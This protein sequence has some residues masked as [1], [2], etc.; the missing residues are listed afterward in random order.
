M[1][2]SFSG[3]ASG[4]DTS[5]WVKSLTALKQAKVTVLED[6]KEN[7]IDAKDALQSIRSFF[8]SFRSTIERIT[9]SRFNIVSMDLFAQNI[10]TSANL[11]VLTATATHEAEEGIYNI[12][13]D[14][15]ATN[16]SAIS[17]FKTTVQE[18]TRATANSLL[19][20]LGVSAGE[21]LVNSPSDGLQKGMRIDADDTIQSFIDK[22]KD[23]GVE[24]SFNEKTSVFSVN[25]GAGD[26]MDIGN[27]GII[28][29]LHL[30]GVNE[31]YTS[32]HL[33]TKTVTETFN[34]AI[35]STYLHEIGVTNGTVI[36]E[37]NDATFTY[38]VTNTST[39]QNFIDWLN[40]NHIDAALD[41]NGIFSIEDAEILDTSTSNLK[42][43]FGLSEEISS[44]SQESK[45][46]SYG[47]TIVTTTTADLTTKLSELGD[48]I[49]ITGNQTVHVYDSNNVLHTITVTSSSTLNSFFTD[50][51]EAGLNAKLNNDGTVEITGGTIATT[52]SFDAISALGL[53]FEPYTGWATGN[54][55]TETIETFE[56]VTYGTRLV[57]DLGV[58][59]G[60][61]QVTKPDGTIDYLKIYS[62]Q[63]IGMM[64]S[65]LS[66]MGI[67]SE[68]NEETG[69]LS[70][71]GG[72]FLTL[73]DSDVAYLFNNGSIRD[74]D[75]SV[76][77]S[78]Y[79]KATDLLTLLYGSPTISATQ[80]SVSQTY[81]RSRALTYEVTNTYQA[82]K[83][84]SLGTLGL[85]SAGNVIF[86]VRGEERTINVATTT[87]IDELLNKFDAVG[88]SATFDEETSK[89]YLENTTIKTT[90]TGTLAEVLNLEKTISG[91]YTTS[92]N[93]ITTKIN[94]I[95]ATRDTLLSE[96]GITSNENVIVHN[97]V[98]AAKTI[99]VT[100]NT[101]LG[102]LID[103]I[104]TV[105]GVTATLEDGILNIEGGYLEN[106]VVEEALGLDTDITGFSNAL[107]I[108]KTITL[109]GTVDQTSSLENIFATMGTLNKVASGYNLTFNGK[110]VTVSAATT[111]DQVINQINNLGGLA[112]LDT[113]GR[114]VIEGGDLAGTVANALGITSFTTTVSVS[115]TGNIMNTTTVVA[116]TGAT[117][118]AELGIAN[119][120]TITVKDALNNQVTV[121]T[122]GSAETLNNLF[123]KLGNANIEASIADGVVTIKSEKGN[124]VEGTIATKLGLNK[125]TNT[126]VVNTTQNS[127]ALTKTVT[128]NATND[129]TL[130]QIFDLNGTT[131][132]SY[133]LAFN[134]VAISVNANTNL[135]NIMNTIAERGGSA[136]IDAD[137]IL[138]VEG[139]TLTGTVANALGITSV[140]TTIGVTQSGVLLYQEET[141]F[142]DSNTTFADLG[143]TGNLITTVYNSNDATVTTLTVTTGDT[144]GSFINQLKTYGIDAVIADG[145]ISLSSD[146]GRYIKDTDGI[147][148]KLGISTA[149]DTQ[150]VSTAQTSTAK[151]THS[152]TELAD[153][154]TTLEAIFAQAGKTVVY[155]DTYFNGASVT[156]A[157]TDSV[158]TL[159][160]KI[161]A[162][163]G[164][165]YLDETGRLHVDNG[166]FTGSVATNLGMVAVITTTAVSATGA[167]QTYTTQEFITGDTKISALGYGASTITVRGVDKVLLGTITTNADMTF[168]DILTA[169]AGYDISGTITNGVITLTSTEGNYVEGGIV[170]S[171]GISSST[172]ST[173]GTTAGM[174][175]TSSTAITYTTTYMTTTLSESTKTVYGTAVISVTKP[176]THLVDF[177][178]T[179][180]Y[181]YD[182]VTVES[183]T[184][185]VYTTITVMN[186][187]TGT[188]TLYITHVHTCTE[189]TT[190]MV[191][192]VVTH[193]LTTTT[194]TPILQT[195]TVKATDTITLET[196]SIG[197]PVTVGETAVGSTQV[198]YYKNVSNYITE[199]TKITLLTDGTTPIIYKMA[200][201]NAGTKVAL[202]TLSSSA[203]VG[204][205]ISWINTNTGFSVTLS[206]GKFV[207]VE[208]TE[209]TNI[210][211]LMK[212]NTATAVQIGN[213]ETPYVQ[214]SISSSAIVTKTS[215]TT[216]YAAG[217]S[218]LANAFAA[219]S[220]SDKIIVVQ[221]GLGAKYTISAAYTIANLV[222]GLNGVGITTEY[223]GTT[224]RFNFTTSPTRITFYMNNTSNILAAGTDPGAAEESYLQTDSTTNQTTVTLTSTS[225]L[226]TF[227]TFSAQKIYYSLPNGTTGAITVNAGETA[228][229]LV[230]KLNN[231][232]F[233]ASVSNGRIRIGDG[234]DN[235]NPVITSI[236]STLANILKLPTTGYPMT[237][238]YPSGITDYT[239]G[240]Y[241][242]NA[243]TTQ[244][245]TLN[246]TTTWKDLFD[247]SMEGEYF[248]LYSIKEDGTMGNLMSSVQI[249]E[250]D[251]VLNSFNNIDGVTATISNG[252]LTYTTE[253]FYL[254]LIGGGG[255]TT[256][257]SSSGGNL[258]DRFNF[259][260]T[261]NTESGDIETYTTVVTVETEG[262]AVVT[263]YVPTT[264][265]TTV[266]NTYNLNNT[267]NDFGIAGDV[268]TV[269]NLIQVETYFE[270]HTRLFAVGFDSATVLPTYTSASCVTMDEFYA[271]GNGT[272]VAISSASD[273]QKLSEMCRTSAGA[274]ATSGVTFF[275]TNDIDMEGKAFYGIGLGSNAFKGTFDGCGYIIEDVTW[276]PFQSS[277]NG[278]A[279]FFNNIIGATIKNL[280]IANFSMNT[281][282]AAAVGGLVGSS[283][284]GTIENCHVAGRIG[285]S[286][287]NAVMGG[288]IGQVSAGTTS[289][290]LSW[291]NIEF[292]GSA[293]AIGGAVGYATAALVMD[294]VEAYT[295][296]TNLFA[297][298]LYYGGLIGIMQARVSISHAIASV[299]THI[300]NRL[301]AGTTGSGAIVGYTPLNSTSYFDFSDVYASDRLLAEYS[302]VGGKN[303]SLDVRVI[304][305]GP[306]HYRDV[307]KADGNLTIEEFLTELGAT[308][309]RIVDG[310]LYFE[311]SKLFQE[312][313]FNHGSNVTNGASYEFGKLGTLAIYA[314]GSDELIWKFSNPLTET[315]NVSGTYTTTHQ[316]E[317]TTTATVY[318]TTISEHT[319]EKTTTAPVTLTI[320][321]TY[322]Y[323]DVSV[324]SKTGYVSYTTKIEE[325][326]LTTD[327]ITVKT[328]GSISTTDYEIKEVTATDLVINTSTTFNQLEDDRSL[329]ANAKATIYSDGVFYTVTVNANDTIG[330][331]LTEL[332]GYG[333]AGN[334]DASGKVNL[335][336]DKEAYIYS[337]DATLKK[338]LAITTG[339]NNTYKSSSYVIMKNSTS[340]AKKETI[341]H[342]AIGSTT[343]EQ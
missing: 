308:N 224:G 50:L 64:M 36:V 205:F 65:D 71:T 82:T 286:N 107:G 16:T 264:G 43:A 240:V 94:D 42:S 314:E 271:T 318:K 222:S 338:A 14:K 17:K 312:E 156:I 282:N 292:G 110:T 299:D 285:S 153:G 248:Y 62:G 325:T 138:H 67:Y 259:T 307:V 265:G 80:T 152:I 275:L 234:S 49:T 95:N 155:D 258:T 3:L 328:T 133:S 334:I 51:K 66:N 28:D 139:G 249:S 233:S 341:T 329:T 298:C 126:T 25:V 343:L 63:T 128:Y 296:T 79:K 123:D 52:G 194:S 55:L 226:S 274:A 330:D 239:T 230:T 89:I 209:E 149:I 216:T 342:T 242:T 34:A 61:L 137:G 315:I 41:E 23:I 59:E 4:L 246:A 189:A 53:N 127:A 21:I 221:E 247:K 125:V 243:A 218:Y 166:T 273:I 321:S 147:A 257:T 284:Q 119:N 295:N 309:I 196:S 81:A 151:V 232:G 10:A 236:D 173:V 227:G 303:Y 313:I 225:T 37:A 245:Y 290:S 124:Y 197:S 40:G 161:I 8:T 5:S 76:P 44:Q 167:V 217:N 131:L 109:T 106:T 177:T 187:T 57:D 192:L 188:Q 85:T 168:G 29:A 145:I 228:S 19:K 38:N 93:L 32:E 98:G 278:P 212:N 310:Y 211:L 143:A 103:S 237:S 340:T 199:D 46:L 304:S 69:V 279:G 207:A 47:T 87:T 190:Q 112:Y 30:T 252:K 75:G 84:T 83:T 18:T 48:G 165:A 320:A 263:V 115:S 235:K 164:N 160:N 244:T 158:N 72:D 154:N 332:A 96:L 335:I 283:T 20:D 6:E 90:G 336:G 183:K 214:A 193:T 162:L 266:T 311:T 148:H 136:W 289:I 178:V 150:V 306:V 92:N 280:G 121:I 231:V 88:I 210:Y 251:K 86:D 267:C 241:T 288:L 169:F 142:A 182:D 74:E 70:I 326:T 33:E 327:Y 100:G 180:S 272:Y 163:G 108:V 172:V 1:S 159:I 215:T 9:D 269:T 219:L 262:T 132:S 317:K 120:S 144:I 238:N 56:I 208:S 104:N 130:K 268:I 255:W 113:S 322:T 305:T 319:I 200:Y 174:L 11:N 333:I 213:F 58:K 300:T 54:A 294:R 301:P 7:I 77:A 250:T 140:T 195:I 146:T 223:D 135:G 170:A 201:T 206:D 31:G 184:G 198:L 68:L 105:A 45:Q 129:T 331:F 134:D 270:S 324:E 102:S 27:T 26:I 111:L 175:A 254:R 260:Y 60:Y 204:D 35:G 157:E 220:T 261:P 287:T 171:L 281:N 297:N 191:D 203:T 12:K 116:A 118:M 99:T 186:A 302:I 276:T 2:I 277:Y 229:S 256:A 22:L 15:I 91:K 181:T 73:T 122:M 39:L 101:T 339:E 293:R 253:G 13:V 78:R 117:T 24:A 176:V 323:D 141:S 316:V 114:V 185:T 202:H 291:S 179:S 97:S 337:M